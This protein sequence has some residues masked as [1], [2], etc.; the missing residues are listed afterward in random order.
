MAWN[1]VSS[2]KSVNNLRGLFTVNALSRRSSSSVINNSDVIV[3]SIT[4]SVAESGDGERQYFLHSQA[5]HTLLTDVRKCVMS[6]SVGVRI[7]VATC[8]CMRAHEN[9]Q[10]TKFFIF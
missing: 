3:I 2:S 4:V 6:V 9:K 7:R 1:S 10:E 8:A 5:H